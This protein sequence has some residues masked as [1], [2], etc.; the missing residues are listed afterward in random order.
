MFSQLAS[1][2]FIAPYWVDNDP[3][4]GGS[5]SYEVHTGNSSL[6]SQVSNVISSTEAVEFSGTWMLVA[7]WLD[8]PL[9]GQT[10]VSK[11]FPSIHHYSG[12]YYECSLTDSY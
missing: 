5:V 8:V 3:S 9:F 1:G 2:S 4:M 12:V 7:Y 11:V 6:L 10:S